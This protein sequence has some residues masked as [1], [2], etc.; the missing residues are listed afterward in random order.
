MD[1][2]GILDVEILETP[3]DPLD[4]R[5]PIGYGLVLGFDTRARHFVLLA[6]LSANETAKDERAIPSNGST[7]HN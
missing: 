6:A 2:I 1:Q 4:F 5:G 7:I 3:T